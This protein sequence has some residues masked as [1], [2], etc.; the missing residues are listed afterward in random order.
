MNL[1]NAYSLLGLEVEATTEK[2]VNDAYKRLI[3]ENHPDK[4]GNEEIASDLN[5][6]RKIIINHL[7]RE[8]GVALVLFQALAKNKKQEEVRQKSREAYNEVCLNATSKYKSEHTWK[9]NAV[10][11]IALVSFIVSSFS[12][13]VL[14]TLEVNT[15]QLQPSEAFIDSVLKKSKSKYYQ[16]KI[17]KDT[18][19]IKENLFLANS[20]VSR[21]ND[22]GSL[23]LN[24]MGYK[25]W[26]KIDSIA[27]EERAYLAM[28]R[29][30]VY[31]SL[32]G[33]DEMFSLFIDKQ[34]KK[35]INHD[36]H[37]TNYLIK[38]FLL[39]LSFLLAVF[40]AILQYQLSNF[41]RALQSIKSELENRTRLQNL[42]AALVCRR[43]E[44]RIFYEDDL[45]YEIDT[46]IRNYAHEMGAWLDATKLGAHEF[47][48]LVVFK[49]QEKTLIEEMPYDNVLT[50]VKY[51]ICDDRLND[52]AQKLK[53]ERNDKQI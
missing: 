43:I 10:A 4:G 15:E 48:K 6:A 8:D 24:S 20:W 27:N 47:G 2:D 52:I 51:K 37:T 22:S 30:E 32:Y 25:D 45:M 38:S 21:N 11:I 28:R 39:L 50:P 26:T 16:G 12:D 9:R 36:A 31:D 1:L 19:S 53:A 34:Y 3:L 35:T 18:L 13:K 42:L 40:G 49:A 7:R 14:P 46:V 29:T 33:N 17:C 23:I 41:D 44:N 5:Q